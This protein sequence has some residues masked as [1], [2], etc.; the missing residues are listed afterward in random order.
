MTSTLL[1]EP[2]SENAAAT[3]LPLGERLIRAGVLSADEL[4]QAL[5]QQSAKKL[6]LGE[7]LVE[8]GFVD[9][10]KLLPCIGAQVGIP[11]VR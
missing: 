9:E 1:E 2:R 11:T 4:E 7:M 3:V 6:K 5:Q 10:E 8:M